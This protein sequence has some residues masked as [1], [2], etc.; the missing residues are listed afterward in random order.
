ME[1][2]INKVEMAVLFLMMLLTAAMA[3]FA[4]AA[5][6]QEATIFTLGWMIFV[7]VLIANMLLFK[8]YRGV[9]R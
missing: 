1:N 3:G 9:K 5:K 8:I 2:I 6:T 7:G 4:F